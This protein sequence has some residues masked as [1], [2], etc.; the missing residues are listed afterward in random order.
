MVASSSAEHLT[1]VKTVMHF[2]LFHLMQKRDPALTSADVYHDLLDRVRLAEDIGMTH[3]WIAEH[4][5]TDYCLAPSPLAV[6]AW[7]A[8]QT[9]RMLFAPGILVLPLYE[10]VRLAQEI[11]SVDIMC[12][13]RL[14]LGIGIGY[15]DYEFRGFRHSLEENGAR[16]V[17]VLDIIETALA[18]G[19]L[20]YDGKH[21]KIS[22][23]KLALK[24]TK[25]HLTTY[26]A[27]ATSHPALPQRAVQ[28][29]YIPFVYNGFS[30][31][32]MVES[33]RE[34]Y[35][36]LAREQGVDE[37]TIG[38]AIERFVYV[39]DSKSDARWAAENF[40]YTARAARSLRFDY[41]ELEGT[42]IKDLPF[43]GEPSVDEI[44]ANGII[45]DAETCAEKIVD[46]MRRARLSHYACLIG[47]GAMEQTKVLRSLE[48]IGA[49]VMPLVEKTIETQNT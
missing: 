44:I 18:T 10:P 43:E 31:F 30:P 38:M 20:S 47:V 48:R 36:E 23:L 24:P 25:P 28:K 35:D 46:E 15:Q 4:H 39:T 6:I 9:K 32:D 45:G 40:R 2:G 34:R 42:T 27:G 8:G 33:I 26:L 37:K 29:G 16:A 21:H 17:E 41:V 49:E 12:D 13:G 11:A 19:E 14:E 1:K 3:S 22:D 5:F 7:L